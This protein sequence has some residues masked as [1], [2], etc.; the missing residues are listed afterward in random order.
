MLLEA[1]VDKQME[2]NNNIYNEVGK[3]NIFGYTDPIFTLWSNSKLS[4][5]T[6]YDES[7]CTWYSTH[8][9]SV[10]N[11]IEMRTANLIS[12]GNNAKLGFI[13]NHTNRTYGQGVISVYLPNSSTGVVAWSPNQNDNTWVSYAQ[14][15]RIV[16]SFKYSN[17]RLLIYVQCSA[18]AEQTD[19]S[20]NGNTYHY[21]LDTYLKNYTTTYPYIVRIYCK[22]AY[23]D[24][25]TRTLFTGNTTT[26]FGP[27]IGTNVSY[28]NTEYTPTIG[29]YSGVFPVFGCF[30]TYN[31]APLNY[32]CAVSDEFTVL[33]YGNYNDATWTDFY[34]IRRPYI[35]YFDGFKEFCIKAACGYGLPVCTTDTAA[36]TGT[37]DSEDTYI[38]K[39]E[40]G[41][42]TQNITH[43]K[44]NLNLDQI[45]WENEDAWDKGGFDPTREPDPNSYT[46]KIDLAKPSLSTVGIFNRSFAMTSSG[47]TQLSDFL[48]NSDETI[49]NQIIDGLKLLGDNPLGAIIDLRL[50]PFNVTKLGSGNSKNIIIGRT[51][52]GVQGIE[53]SNNINCVIDMGS[54][55][56]YR[57]FN[58]FLDYEPFTTASLYIPYCGIVSI[59]TAEFVDKNISVKLI[60]DVTTGSCTA[61]IF[62]DNIPYLYKNGVIGVDVP[63]S[64]TNS[65]EYASKILNGVVSGTVNTAMGVATGNAGQAASSAMGLVNT[66]LSLNN[67]SVHTIGSSSPACSFWQPQNCYFIIRR[68]VVNMPAN[69]GHTVGYACNYQAKIADCKGYTQTYNVDVSTIN[70]PEEE[71]NEIA[72]ILNTGF[73]A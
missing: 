66:G 30:D 63:I 68:P 29:S 4:L 72:K 58:N 21:T 33:F 67:N 39:I 12:T 43:G 46:D 51:D 31:D 62:V 44:D 48:W 34:G 28:K 16:T 50:Y 52:T 49:F 47:I 2:I 10:P 17:I 41:N 61:V 55:S 37:I 59:P 1:E 54:C 53:L 40:N 9:Y 45:N 32:S 22:P 64:A 71:K 70:A 20:G 56:F 18:T 24:S 8:L 42:V 65:A 13:I 27:Y 3:N 5:N 19:N 14:N 23:G 26:T 35:K 15:K 38:A 60:V 57:T 36:Q 69:Y 73:F 25:S 7:F 6:P 11:T